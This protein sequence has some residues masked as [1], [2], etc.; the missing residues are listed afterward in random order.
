M[1]PE[2]YIEQV[3]WR[4]V[5][6]GEFYNIEREPK[7]PGGGGSLYIEIPTSMVTST[8][9]FLGESPSKLQDGN[10]IQISARVLQN[11]SEIGLIEFHTKKG[12]RMRI[13]RQNRRQKNTLRHPAWT[14]KNGFPQAP[15]GLRN[16]SADY[17][18]Y[19]PEGGLRIF[20][21]KSV[22]GNYYAGF[23]KGPRPEGL[24]PA[25]PNSQLYPETD[26]PGGVF[27]PRKEN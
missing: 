20:L 9:E 1:I 11:P 7:L 27:S 16:D 26:V 13:A 25:D 18:R 21:V 19:F 10:P 22:E 14:A 12:G 23:T 3:W 24:D 17:A 5:R 15:D 6:K 2:I 8:L 4:N